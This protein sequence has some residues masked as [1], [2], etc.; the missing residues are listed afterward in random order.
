MKASQRRFPLS[1]LVEILNNPG[2]LLSI[3]E[4]CYETIQNIMTVNRRLR[5]YRCG[6]IA[7][8]QDVLQFLQNVLRG[9]PPRE[10]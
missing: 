3:Y 10:I 5:Y 9:K 6:K 7:G 1:L 8:Q 2:V 4:K